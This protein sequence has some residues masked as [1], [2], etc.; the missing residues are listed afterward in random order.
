[1]NHATFFITQ[2]QYDW[3][4][5]ALPQP[6]SRTGH[7]STPNNEL[8]NGILF[9]LKTSCRWQDIPTSI[10]DHDYST[11]WR[12]LNFWRKRGALKLVWQHILILLDEQGELDLTL[13][14]IDGSLVQSPKFKDGTGYSGKHHRTGTNI[15]LLTDKQGLPLTNSTTKGNRHDITSAERTVNKSCGSVPSAD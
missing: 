14:S 15:S 8:L 11:C 1:M 9:V 4:A 7:P 2:P 13:G 12:R 5:A 3:L 10:C 6:S